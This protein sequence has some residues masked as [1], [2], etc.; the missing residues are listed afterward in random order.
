MV[1]KIVKKNGKIWL[2]KDYDVFFR[3]P[4]TRLIGTYD[5][6]DEIQAQETPQ[7]SISVDDV[8]NVST[9]VKKTR[10]RRNKKV[11]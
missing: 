8:D 1:E 4:I 7:E 2:W 9:N 11:D 6:E 5:E 3:N 10:Q